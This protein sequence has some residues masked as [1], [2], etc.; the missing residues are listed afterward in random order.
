MTHTKRKNFIRDDSYLCARRSGI[1]AFFATRYLDVT[2][3]RL[4]LVLALIAA[5]ALALAAP[6]FAYEDGIT[7]M[8][9]TTMIT[10]PRLLTPRRT[11][12]GPAPPSAPI[13]A[14]KSVHPFS[15]S[16]ILRECPSVSSDP[17]RWIP[18]AA[19]MDLRTPSLTF[20]LSLRRPCSILAAP[21]STSRWRI[22]RPAR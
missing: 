12:R 20:S 22:I 6:A 10:L 2:M 19:P 8:E 13:K 9:I 15:I 4:N 5:L 3:A 1:D 18:G 17:P 16:G 11:R 21:T 7:T 14:P